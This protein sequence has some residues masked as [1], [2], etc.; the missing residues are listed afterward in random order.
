MADFPRCL[1]IFR[2]YNKGERVMDLA[3]QLHMS[4]TSIYEAIHL[5]RS[6]QALAHPVSP[7]SYRRLEPDAITRAE[8]ASARAEAPAAPPFRGR[9]VW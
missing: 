2:R 3:V 7:P 4:R 1:E 5:C 9:I 8:I 6:R